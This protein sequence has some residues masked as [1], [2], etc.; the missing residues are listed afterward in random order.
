MNDLAWLVQLFQLVDIGR[1]LHRSVW[2][3]A[4]RLAKEFEL[5]KSECLAFLFLTLFLMMCA[6]GLDSIGLIAWISGAPF[7]L[8][9]AC[10]ILA[11]PVSFVAYVVVMLFI[12]CL[13][14]A[15]LQEA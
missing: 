1:R 8:K 15:S 10:L 11:I 5:S 13:H 3:L 4:N 2:K 7:L 9:M 14:Q 12:A 6:A